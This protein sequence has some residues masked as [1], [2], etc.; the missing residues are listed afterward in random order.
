MPN[1]FFTQLLDM[2]QWTDYV[3]TFATP[4]RQIM[5]IEPF[6]YAIDGDT[7]PALI[8]ATAP[9]TFSTQMEGDADFVLFYM[10]AFGRVNTESALRV[11]PA[12]LGQITDETTGRSFF[13]EPTPVP[14]F[15]GQGGFPFLMTGPKVIKARSELSLT[16]RSA[17]AVSW[18]GFYFAY[19][20]ARIWY[21]GHN[22][23]A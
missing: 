15:A 2:V 23:A 18:S 11:N 8:T 4:G 3:A 20:G 19:H 7:L 1:A 12:L 10:S 13:S 6:S 5:E 17:Q 9:Q 21:G 22:G 16:V 14:I